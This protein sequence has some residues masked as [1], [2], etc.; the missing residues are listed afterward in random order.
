MSLGIIIKAPEGIV[1]AAESRV[2]L[3]AEKRITDPS[4]AVAKEKISVNFDNANKLLKFNEP[5][6]RFGVVTYGQAAIELR[7]AQS[8]VPEFETTLNGE[9]LSVEMFAQKLSD[10]FLYQ[11]K[12]V[13]PDDWKGQNMIF[14]V[15]GFNDNE[16]YGRVYKLEIPSKPKPVEQHGKVGD[17]YQF[18]ITGGGQHEIM[19]RLMLG[20]DPNIFQVL[21]KKGIITPE[22]A[23]QALPLLDQF[24]LQ[25]PIQFMP[26]QDCVNLAKMIIRTTIDAQSLSVGLR[27]C[28]GAIDIA[29]ITKNSPMRFIKQK[30]ITVN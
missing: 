4:G 1:L 15:A 20:Y 9:R 18:G 10:F 24:K 12:A 23:Q 28:G 19:S 22:Q 16:P 17:K 26:L 7:T 29:I 6:D 30:D 5:Y 25:A 27:G 13:I 3:T 14:D 21:V 2:T 8:L 11:W